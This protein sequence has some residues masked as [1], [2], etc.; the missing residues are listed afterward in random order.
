P[1][2]C[3]TPVFDDVP[4]SSDFAPWINELSARA[5]TGGCG[6]GSNFCPTDPT[7]RQQMAVF[8]L[9]TEEGSSYAPPACVTPAFDDVPCS[10]PFAPWINELVVRE[11][12]AG[13]GGN[14]F[15]PTA[16]VPRD[17]M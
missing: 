15:C 10:N 1:P 8:L 3:V 16:Q 11:V 13:C 4:C 9:K 2:A 12:T 14:N 6:D 5:V 17:Q 7:N